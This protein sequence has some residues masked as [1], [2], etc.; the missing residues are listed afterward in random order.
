MAYT[1][2]NLHLRAGAPGDLSYT[3][4]ATADTLAT[5][6]TAGYFN[7]TDD[8]LALA[9]D[10][11]LWIQAGD[12]NCWGRVSALDSGSV[13]LQ[14]AGG[15]L[16]AQTLGTNTNTA[17]AGDS[18]AKAK[19]MP[20]GAY[21]DGSATAGGDSTASRYVLDAAYPGAEVFV[22]RTDAGTALHT[23]DAGASDA[24]AITFDNLGNRRFIIQQENEFF[25]V[26]GV[27]TTRWRILNAQPIATIAASVTFGG[28]AS[29]FPGGT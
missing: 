13:T 20:V 4:D 9:V 26:V 12:G 14:F 8:D 19:G 24:T 25:H 18:A 11:L 15:N 23:F 28:G 10:D 21:E 17:T 7:N 3:Y 2:G 6:L 22:R 27:S 29:R 1:A 5:V 16:P